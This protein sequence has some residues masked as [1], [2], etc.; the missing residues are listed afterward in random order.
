M[1]KILTHDS[2]FL[3]VRI[4]LT[5]ETKTFISKVQEKLQEVSE[6]FSKELEEGSSSFCVYA[7]FP[8]TNFESPQ[9]KNLFLKI[10]PNNWSIVEPLDGSDNGFE[11]VLVDS[12]GEAQNEAKITLGEILLADENVSASSQIFK[13]HGCVEVAKI[14]LTEE[15]KQE[16][17]KAFQDYWKSILEEAYSYARADEKVSS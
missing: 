8:F 17:I 13:E 4:F 5:E 15:E 9:K 10:A 1:E 3:P 7:R 16:C 6:F 14:F 11:E 12:N 2:Q